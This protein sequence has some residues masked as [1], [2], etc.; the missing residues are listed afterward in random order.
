MFTSILLIPAITATLFSSKHPLVVRVKR[1]QLL[2]QYLRELGMQLALIEFIIANL[3]CLSVATSRAESVIQQQFF[4][5]P[6]MPM[7]VTLYV[8]LCKAST[9]IQD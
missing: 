7:M 3:V 5:V 1:S 6:L 2:W 8:F 9:A 4:E